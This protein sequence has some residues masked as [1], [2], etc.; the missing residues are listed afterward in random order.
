[1]E[2]MRG[3]IRHLVL[4]AMTPQAFRRRPYR[5]LRERERERTHPLNILTW[6]RGSQVTLSRYGYGR[7]QKLNLSQGKGESGKT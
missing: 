2:E 1:M 5:Q 7:G 3:S 4:I 6:F